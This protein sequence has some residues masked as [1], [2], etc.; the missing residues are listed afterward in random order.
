MS[1]DI[2]QEETQDVIQTTEAEATVVE[3]TIETAAPQ[4]ADV[5]ATADDDDSGLFTWGDFDENDYEDEPTVNT[6][7][8]E[9]NIRTSEGEKRNSEKTWWEIAAEKTGLKAESEDD[10]VA[11]M[12][13]PKEIVVTEKDPEIRRLKSLQAKDDKGLVETKLREQGL[14]EAKIDRRIKQ[15]EERGDLEFEADTIRTDI[16]AVMAKRARA[17]EQQEREQ[18]QYIQNFA[19]TLNK[20]IAEKLSKTDSLLGFKV[21]KDEADINKWRAGTEKYFTT[22]QFSK[23]IDAILKEAHD[24]NAERLIELAQ[25]IRA[26]EGIAKGLRQAGKSDK[27]KEILSELEN[28]SVTSPKGERTTDSKTAKGWFTDPALKQKAGIIK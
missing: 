16:N 14:D 13:S 23:D 17:I 5:A 12:S 2:K 26:K 7:A 24:G 4:T 22:N 6:P 10:F 27:A 18:A 9:S 28:S 1:E 20:N 11:K 19:S 25:F 21:G 15:L 8:A 3:P